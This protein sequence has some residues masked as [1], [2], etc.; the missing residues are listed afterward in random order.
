MGNSDKTWAGC[1]H[2]NSAKD[3]TWQ[4]MIGLSLQDM[5]TYL[6]KLQAGNAIILTTST[7][8]QKRHRITFLPIAVSPERRQGADVEYKALLSTAYAFP[9]V[10]SLIQPY[11][12]FHCHPSAGSHLENLMLSPEDAQ[13]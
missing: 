12:S 6:G 1:R 11:L 8:V 5:I 9:I 10:M 4:H 2:A 13:L 3:K 7:F